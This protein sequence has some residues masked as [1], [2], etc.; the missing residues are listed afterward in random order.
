MIRHN[1]NKVD[2]ICFQMA[3]VHEA[4]INCSLT[5]SCLQNHPKPLLIVSMELFLLND[6]PVSATVSAA[7]VELVYI[8]AVCLNQVQKYS[9]VEILSALL[10]LG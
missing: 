10:R 9:N 7:I 6:T 2:L 1:T 8:F 5:L 4:T 3:E